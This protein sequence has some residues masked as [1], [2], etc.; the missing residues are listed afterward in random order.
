VPANQTQTPALSLCMIVRDEQD[1]LPRCLASVAGVVDQLIIVDTGSCDATVRIARQHGALV[2]PYDFTAVDFAAA[3]NHG[4]AHATGRFILVL[5]ADESL[6]PDSVAHL[7][8]HLIAGE[9]VGYILE[10]HNY[11]P[12]GDQPVRVDHAVRLFPNQP[13]YRYRRRVHE[14]VDES[15]LAAGGR[16]QRSPVV[17]NHFLP[18]PDR[19]REKSLVYL[20]LLLAD[21]A[22]EPDDVDR[23]VFLAAEYHKLEMFEQAIEVAERISS[24]CPDD[25]SAQFNA[26][27]YHFAYA[28]DPSR[29]RAE[30]AT[31]LRLRPGDPEG[32]ALLAAIEQAEAATAGAR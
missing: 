19:Q 12:G 21:V 3:R 26:A 10:R 24:L 16:L 32:L 15:I 5:D 1:R 6:A 18:D 27:L 7:R 30:L 20:Q 8:A 4:L 29:A 14:T 31:A 9:P 28:G 23:L 13:E 2:L 11:L 25:F 17:V 22:A